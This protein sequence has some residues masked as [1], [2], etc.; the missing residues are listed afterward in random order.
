MPIKNEEILQPQGSGQHRIGTAV[1][2]TPAI[3]REMDWTSLKR[4]W[5]KELGKIVA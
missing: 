2:V 4:A 3:G 1:P 5:L